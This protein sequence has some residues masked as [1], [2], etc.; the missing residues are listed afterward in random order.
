MLDPLTPSDLERSRALSHLIIKIPSKNSHQ[1]ALA[2][3]FISGVKV[4]NNFHMFLYTIYD[5]NQKE[6]S[7]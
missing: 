2:D 7:S 6:L 3:R 4:S 1:P 5:N